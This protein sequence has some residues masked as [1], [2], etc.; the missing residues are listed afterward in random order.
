MLSSVAVQCTPVNSYFG[1]DVNM[2]WVRYP[3]LNTLTLTCHEGQEFSD[4][5]TEMRVVCE[6]K[7]T[8]IPL[9]LTCTGLI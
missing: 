7:G 3:Y 1:I 9:P 6:A 2:S 5:S 4:E 8:W